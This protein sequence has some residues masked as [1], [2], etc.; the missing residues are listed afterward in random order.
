VK[1]YIRLPAYAAVQ[2]EVEDRRHDERDH[3]EEQHRR[4]VGGRRPVK[5]LR[6][7]AEPADEEREAEHEQQVADDA[8]GDRRL[9]QRDVSAP[10]RDDRDDQ[11]R[12]VAECRV[13]KTAEGRTRPTCELLRAEADDAG[14]RHQ[15]RSRRDEHPR[16]SVRNPR[17]DPGD[18]SGNQQDVERR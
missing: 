3:A 12:G 18:R 9:H 17:Q 13:E 15:R 7:P 10:Q 16:R 5:F 14:E 11:F 1:A 8:P 2:G 4:R 6:A